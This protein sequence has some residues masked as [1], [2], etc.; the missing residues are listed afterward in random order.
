MSNK[1]AQNLEAML[2]KGQDGALLRFGLGKHYFDEKQ[3]QR[4]LPHLQR[5]TEQDEQHSAA[6]KLTARCLHLLQ[7]YDDA[8]QAYQQTLVVAKRNGDKQVCKEVA[9]FL[10][11]LEKQR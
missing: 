4:A 8:E 6:W 10:K 7:H 5:C 3:Y 2:A 1:L 11:K 9:V